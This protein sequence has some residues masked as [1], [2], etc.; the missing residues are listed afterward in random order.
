MLKAIKSWLNELNDVRPFVMAFVDKFNNNR[1]RFRVYRSEKD[2]QLHLIFDKDYKV[3]YPMWL[4]DDLKLC[5][6]QAK[7]CHGKDWIEGRVKSLGFTIDDV[8]WTTFLTHREQVYLYKYCYKVWWDKYQE[9]IDEKL[10]A[11]K[12]TFN[13]GMLNR[14]SK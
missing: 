2:M 13:V 3:F 14:Y 12:H 9:G 4:R 8:E 5:R 6:P 10:K 1:G 11:K 7:G